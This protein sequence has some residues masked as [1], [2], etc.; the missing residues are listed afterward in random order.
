MGFTHPG[1]R[2]QNGVDG[3]FSLF[4][5]DGLF[6][7]VLQQ[8]K[9]FGAWNVLVDLLSFPYPQFSH[10]MKEWNKLYKPHIQ[11]VPLHPHRL[12][13]RGFNQ[14]DIIKNTLFST[15]S[16][17]HLPLLERVIHTEHLANIGNKVRRGRHI[18]NA[19]SYM[20]GEPPKATLLI[21][22]VIT[23]GSTIAECARTL[24]E[25]GVQT[26]LAF[27]LAKG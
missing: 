11:S 7:K 2:I 19:F 13:E 26:V 9:Y 17:N 4:R 10:I 8:S 3:C 14:S 25:V 6:K 23:S 21:D 24:K 20:G 18:R 27:S 15:H 22:D 16:T 12:R 5:Y 1:C